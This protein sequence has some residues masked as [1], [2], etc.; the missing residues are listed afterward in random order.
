MPLTSSSFITNGVRCVFFT[1]NSAFNPSLA[2]LSL[3]E[4]KRPRLDGQ[5]VSLPIPEDA[6]PE[7]PRVQVSNREQ[8]YQVE[9]SPARF[10][11]AWQRPVDLQEQPDV[12]ESALQTFTAYQKAVAFRT[13]RLALTSTRYATRENPA[14]ELVSHFCQSRW[15]ER[16]E[17]HVGA[18]SRTENFE[19]HAHKL[20]RLR[21]Q[22]VNSWVRCKTGRLQQS[23]A[24]KPVVVVEQDLNTPVEDLETSVFSTAEAKQVLQAMLNESDHI[25]RLYFP[26]S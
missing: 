26:E 14:M 2:L 6:P 4:L 24:V 16:S 22:R 21:E 20:F 17:D 23:G 8:S 25:L 5:V 13:G 18:L 19:L 10:S 1:Q 7:I 15:L 12:V 11:F 3:L 9:A